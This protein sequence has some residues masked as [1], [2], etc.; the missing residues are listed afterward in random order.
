MNISDDPSLW[1]PGTLEKYHPGFVYIVVPQRNAAFGPIPILNFF[2][3]KSGSWRH[4]DLEKLEALKVD[5]SQLPPRRQEM[6]ASA[7]P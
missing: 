4:P 7:T 6:P 2:A 5:P 3:H 1:P